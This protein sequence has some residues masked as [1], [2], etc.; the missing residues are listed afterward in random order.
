MDAFISSLDAALRNAAAT[1]VL[2]TSDDEAR[3]SRK[4]LTD[5]APEH[6]RTLTAQARPNVLF[7]AGMAFGKR[8]KNTMLVQLLRSTPFQRRRGTSH[9]SLQGKRRRQERT[10]PPPGNPQAVR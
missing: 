6:E 5:G 10:R 4:Y 2:L 9:S 8:P 7:E 3:L 1:V